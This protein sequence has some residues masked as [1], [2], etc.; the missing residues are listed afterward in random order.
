MKS[1][2]IMPHPGQEVVSQIK[3]VLIPTLN[4]FG[5]ELVEVEYRL[6]NRGWVLRLYIDKEGG[7]SLE[8]CRRVS[9]QVGDLLDVEDLIDRE[10]RLEVSSPGLDRPLVQERDFVRFA[11]K[12]ARIVTH[13]P[14][15]R[16]R[17]FQGRILGVVEHK[18]LIEEN[19]GDKV[20]IPYADI[21]KARLIP[22][23]PGKGRAENSCGRN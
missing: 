23:F 15:S 13:D 7:V 4:F 3:K 22:E 19:T 5:V 14:I 2:E 18:V 1:E 17:N 8:D 11:G 9:E 21:A 20:E 6:E 16:Q 10:Y 12:R